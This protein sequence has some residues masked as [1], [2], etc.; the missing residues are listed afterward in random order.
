MY[1]LIKGTSFLCLKFVDGFHKLPPQIT[2][3]KNE[4]NQAPVNNIPEALTF[5]YNGS[6]KQPVVNN[7]DSNMN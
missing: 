6:N 7:Q 2:T 4:T 3:I 5:N 1:T